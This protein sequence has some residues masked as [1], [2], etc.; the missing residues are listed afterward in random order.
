MAP[1]SLVLLSHWNQICLS[2]RQQWCQTGGTLHL[3]SWSA[4]D[5][6]G[7]VKPLKQTNS[8]KT[9]PTISTCKNPLLCVHIMLCNF[10]LQ[11]RICIS[12]S[13]TTKTSLLG[14]VFILKEE[15]PVVEIHNNTGWLLLHG[16]ASKIKK[17]RFETHE[18]A[19]MCSEVRS[20]ARN[21][22]CCTKQPEGI[23]WF[24]ALSLSPFCSH[25]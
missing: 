4:W 6:C 15:N 1:P 18:S 21:H 14:S 24:P 12:F 23:L 2:P 17:P 10:S 11:D 13:A 22:S 8:N 25:P 19:R 5:G 7:L 9:H 20:S 3:H 16:I